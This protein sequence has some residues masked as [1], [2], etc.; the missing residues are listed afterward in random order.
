MPDYRLSRSFF[1]TSTAI[2]APFRHFRHRS[3]TLPSPQILFLSKR[4]A[5]MSDGSD[6]SDGVFVYTRIYGLLQYVYVAF[7]LYTCGYIKVRH[8]R[9]FRHS[10]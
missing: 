4:L 3:V 2:L 9:H 1:L 7:F 6:G 5:S 10:K 8:F